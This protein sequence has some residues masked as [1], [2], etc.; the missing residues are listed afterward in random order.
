VLLWVEQ[1]LDPLSD[2]HDVAPAMLGRGVRM[3]FHCC[4]VI[5][6]RIQG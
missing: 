6:L 5:L 4:S 3:G 2:D 1:G